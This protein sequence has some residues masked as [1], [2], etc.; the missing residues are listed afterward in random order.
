MLKQILIAKILAAISLWNTIAK[1]SLQAS[2]VSFY[3]NEK[4]N[5]YLWPETKEKGKKKRMKGKKEMEGNGN[6]HLE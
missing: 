1:I 5:H 6:K 3:C 2:I 4:N